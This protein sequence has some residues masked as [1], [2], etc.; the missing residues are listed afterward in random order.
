[1]LKSVAVIG[2]GFGGLAISNYVASYTKSLTVFQNNNSAS[3]VA[4]S[5]QHS[6]AFPAV[7]Y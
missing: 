7:I 2:G 5:D 4:V 3:T 6:L 1:M